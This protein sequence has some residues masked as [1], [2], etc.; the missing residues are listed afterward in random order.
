MCS[1]YKL[2]LI[3]VSSLSI[4]FLLSINYLHSLKIINV[5]ED[6]FDYIQLLFYPLVSVRKLFDNE[7]PLG[8]LFKWVDQDPSNFN[9]I[10]SV[11]RLV[12]QEN[13]TGDIEVSYLLLVCYQSSCLLTPVTHPS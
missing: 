2:F 4:K 6:N 3:L 8:L 1:S 7:S 5:I 10:L 13:E 11:K 9:N 12:L